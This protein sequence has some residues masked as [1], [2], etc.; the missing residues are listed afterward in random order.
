MVVGQAVLQNFTLRRLIDKG[1]REWEDSGRSIRMAPPAANYVR[2]LS[3]AFF[4]L[5]LERKHAIFQFAG[6][7]TEELNKI[8]NCKSHL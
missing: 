4:Y 7:S 1:C 5:V 3:V 6:L 8:F 2:W